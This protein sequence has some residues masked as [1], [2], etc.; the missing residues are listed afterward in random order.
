MSCGCGL[1]EA[2]TKLTIPALCSGAGPMIRRPPTDSSTSCAR[3]V[4]SR[5]WA[6]MA[7]RP[8]ELR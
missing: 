4:K 6:A 2:N 3:W 8:T 7:S 1:P 5:S